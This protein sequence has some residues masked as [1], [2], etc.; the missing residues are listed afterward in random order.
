[1]N[2]TLVTDVATDNDMPYLRHVHMLQQA[3]ILKQ[4]IN[5]SMKT[6]KQKINIHN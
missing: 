2:D 1:M 5:E 4:A 6:H 3:D